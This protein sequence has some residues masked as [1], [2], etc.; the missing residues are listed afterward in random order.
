METYTIVDK[1]ALALGAGLTLLGIVV[2]GIVE[3]LAGKPYGAAPVEI[4]NDAG[5]VVNTLYPAVDPTLRT[6]LVVAG[7][8]VLLGWGC[9]RMVGTRAV[10]AD[11]RD[12]D[13]TAD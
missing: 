4:T 2:L 12:A 7:L 8:V 1:A 11:A 3:M 6:G 10:D 9:Y 5:E 13:V